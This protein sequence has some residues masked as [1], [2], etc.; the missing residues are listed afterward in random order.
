MRY[1]IVVLA[2]FLV[3]SLSSAAGAT[4]DVGHVAL[5]RKA[6]FAVRDACLSSGSASYAKSKNRLDTLCRKHSVPSADNAALTCFRNRAQ[7]GDSAAEFALGSMVLVG[8]G[9]A[10]DEFHALGWFRKAAAHGHS[11]A[12]CELAAMYANGIGVRKDANVSAEW[13]R[14]S[15]LQGDPAGQFQL[16]QDYTNAEGVPED[17]KQ[18]FSWRLKSAEQGFVK[19]QLEVAG[20]YSLGSGVAAS[21]E[22]AFHWYEKATE[23]NSAAAQFGT[24]RAYHFGYG[25]NKD[26]SQAANWY[27]KAAQQGNICAQ[28]GLATLYTA[29]KGVPEDFKQAFVWRKKAAEADPYTNKFNPPPRC[30]FESQH[31][32]QRW[33]AMMY[34]NGYGVA[35]NDHQGFHW[36]R[37]GLND[38]K[39]EQ[40]AHF[41]DAESTQWIKNGA[42]ANDVEA[43][44]MLA[45]MYENGWGLPQDTKAGVA[46]TL[47]AAEQ[48]DSEAQRDL[49]TI[50][51]GQDFAKS[52]FWSKKLVAQDEDDVEANGLLEQMYRMG[53]GTVKDAAAAFG[54]A[55]RSGPYVLGRDYH[56][57]VGVVR[58]DRK[59]MELFEK[60][61]EQEDPRAACA[62]GSLYLD[63]QGIAVDKIQAY[64]WLIRGTGDNADPNCEAKLA[65]LIKSLTAKD[66]ALTQSDSVATKPVSR[67]RER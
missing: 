14:K 31:A 24:G 7:Q 57:G 36:L 61:V 13:T 38:A 56:L 52:I 12:Q 58:D 53:Q 3:T 5:W 65:T 47:R 42:D 2:I 46:L 11:G 37:L 62:I 18:A 16:A 50:Y 19:A 45:A 15:A 34:R 60:A 55:R 66:I 4:S 40:V 63:G 51:F 44:K 9:V 32:A 20:D 41:I 23:Q 8:N 43:I 30:A 48:G 28:E 26:L 64:R 6:N 17:P 29:G 25:V 22:L 1:S 10:A 27:R 21:D 49:A 39:P 33:L 54:F 59:A 35:K 67:K